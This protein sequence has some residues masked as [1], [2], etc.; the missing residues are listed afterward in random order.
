MNKPERY[1]EIN[2]VASRLVALQEKNCFTFG[3]VISAVLN[4]PTVKIVRCVNCKHYQEWDDSNPPTCR[5]WTDQWDMSTEPN[6][7]C[8]YGELKDS[9]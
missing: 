2:E 5:M 9:F 3:S 4:I 6:G 8:H 1:L 7:Y